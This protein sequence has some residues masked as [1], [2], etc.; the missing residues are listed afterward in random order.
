MWYLSIP[1]QEAITKATDRIHTPILHLAKQ[2]IIHLLTFRQ[3]EG[4]P[5]GSN[6]SSILAIL[7]MDRVILFTRFYFTSVY[8]PYAFLIPDDAVDRRKLF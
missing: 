4:L 6:I 7:F 5:M 1:I 3:K 2:E 8:K